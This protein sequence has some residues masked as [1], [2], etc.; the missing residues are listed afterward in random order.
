MCIRDRYL[1]GTSRS[2]P[3]VIV[4]DAAWREVGHWGSRPRELQA[5]VLEARKTTPKE[6]LYPQI[7]RWYAHD[8]GETTLREIL[9]LLP[10]EDLSLTA[11]RPN[12]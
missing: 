11:G 12:N 8:R 4:L 10:S 5:W 9:E 1:T 3:I 7:R 2:V 6:Q